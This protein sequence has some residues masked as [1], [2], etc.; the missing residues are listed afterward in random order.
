MRKYVIGFIIALSLVVL[1]AAAKVDNRQYLGFPVA[2]Y[3]TTQLSWVAGDANSASTTLYNVNGTIERIDIIVSDANNA[4]NNNCTITFADEGGTTLKA[5]TAF[6]T[7]PAA[8]TI[9]LATS[10]STQF[11][12]IPSCGNV[13][14]TVDPNGAPGGAG[15]LV[16]FNIY[17]R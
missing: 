7:T 15:W 8:R 13:V 5:F 4:P 3:S 10:D 9:E 11:D 2:K 16:D 17:V 1:L 14:V 12:A 6:P